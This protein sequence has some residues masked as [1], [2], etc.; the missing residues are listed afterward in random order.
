[1]VNCRKKKPLRKQIC[2]SVLFRFVDTSC[3][4][5]S[6]IEV[7]SLSV[8]QL[9]F[10]LT[11]KACLSMNQ[12]ASW[13]KYPLAWKN[14]WENS[15]NLIRF[16]YLKNETGFCFVCSVWLEK[17][18]IFTFR[19]D[20]CFRRQ[21]RSEKNVSTFFCSAR[22]SDFAAFTFASMDTFETFRLSKNFR[23]R[24][25]QHRFRFRFRFTRTRFL[26]T[27][28][29]KFFA[30][31]VRLWGRKR[32][33][34]KRK[35]VRVCE[36]E[37]ER[38]GRR[39]KETKRAKECAR[40]WVHLSLTCVCVCV[41]VCERE[42]ERERE[43]GAAAAMWRNSRRNSRRRRKRSNRKKIETTEISDFSE[44]CLTRKMTPIFFFAFPR[45]RS[46]QSLNLADW[47]LNFWMKKKRK[48]LFSGLL[49]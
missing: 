29:P 17:N 8:F 23:N 20:F 13:P 1:M 44:W 35:C 28:E 22:W 4:K 12:T 33:V 16:F 43:S 48:D 38:E 25:S 26:K 2:F 31:K 7:S 15:M 5:Q 9:Y 40:L 39:Q 45:D 49:L 34:G 42:R 10:Q 46:C 14:S 11:S 18:G 30:R 19:F 37:R 41:C 32:R 27:T 21:F 36:R 24:K 6:A 47:D 3:G